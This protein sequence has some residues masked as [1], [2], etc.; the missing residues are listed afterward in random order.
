MFGFEPVRIQARVLGGFV[1]GMPKPGARRKV[2]AEHPSLNPKN[3]CHNIHG[4]M[5][6]LSINCL[7]I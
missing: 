4:F 6:I 2:D 3:S 5:R 1:Q 7:G